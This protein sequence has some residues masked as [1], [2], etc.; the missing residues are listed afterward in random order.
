M[1][2]QEQTTVQ[3]QATATEEITAGKKG[4]QKPATNRQQTNTISHP[5]DVAA[6]V[7]ARMN[8]INAKKDE[9]TI[10]IKGL[11]DFTQQMVQA[12]AEQ[13]QL[14]QQL[15]NRVKSLEKKSG[16]NGTNGHAVMPDT[17]NA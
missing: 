4:E 5:R 13:V 11:T 1:I 10:A 9:L 17:P 15:S 16:A 7:M 6:V 12:Y 2:K 3:E 8:I 14:I